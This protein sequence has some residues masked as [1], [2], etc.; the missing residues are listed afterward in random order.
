MECYQSEAQATAWERTCERSVTSSSTWVENGQLEVEHEQIEALG[1]FILRF[2]FGRQASDVVGEFVVGTR[3]QN[4]RRN[5]ARAEGQSGW[6]VA[7][8]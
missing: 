7:R 2:E 4:P 1:L 3:T 6:P 5:P 8:P